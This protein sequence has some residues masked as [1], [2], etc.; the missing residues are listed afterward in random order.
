LAFVYQTLI[1]KCLA[2]ITQSQITTTHGLA[3]WHP[4]LSAWR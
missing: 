3:E 2:L 4:A 1:A